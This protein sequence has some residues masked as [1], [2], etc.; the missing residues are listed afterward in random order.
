MEPQRDDRGREGHR[1]G[2]HIADR[3]PSLGV[4]LCYA[5]LAVALC[6][7]AVVHPASHLVGSCCDS[8]V[9]VSYL[10][11]TGVALLHGHQPFITAYLNAPVGVNALWQPSSS[12]ALGVAAIPFELLIGPIATYNLFAIM[13]VAL[14]G[15]SAYLV[16]RRWVGGQT[17]PIV[18]GLVFGFSSYMMVQT[19]AGHLDLTFLALVPPVL[20]IIVSL[21]L[22]HARSPWRSGVALGVLLVVQLLINQEILSDLVIAGLVVTATLAIVC[23]QQVVVAL[24]RLA[25]GVAVAAV[26]FLA[27]GAWPLWTA[28]FGSLRPTNPI[29]APS[30]PTDLLSFVSPTPLISLAPQWLR[31]IDAGWFPDGVDQ[32]SAYIGIVLLGV[33]VAAAIALRR[34]PVVRVASLGAVIMAILSLGPNLRV[35]NHLTGIPLPWAVFDHLPLLRFAVTD[36][37]VV[38]TWLGVAVVLAAFVRAATEAR[39]RGRLLWL[40]A[41][42]TGLV[43]L[44]PFPLTTTSLPTPSIFTDPS[45]TKALPSGGLVYV[46]PFPRAENV[47]PLQWQAETRMRFSMPGGYVLVPTRSGALASTTGAVDDLSQSLLDLQAGRSPPPRIEWP[48]L[49]AELASDRAAAVL[50]GPM[51]HE[52]A[53]REFLTMMLASPPR[54]IG[55]VYV[56]RLG[57]H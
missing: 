15:W 55:G 16:L 27:L 7:K 4:L 29:I 19:I 45:L 39:L 43:L 8:L 2:R 12:I 30:I 14:S 56:W 26:S 41:L 53:V 34:Q 9:A 1:H 42:V 23:R 37:F 48:T 32:S 13:A 28:L 51:D 10:Q 11:S 25:V 50:V 22:G 18:G 24:P 20:A 46:A 38:F 3:L 31:T 52:R 35:A 40:V 5:C 33:T 21:A 54:P 57:R 47:A 6:H 49:R 44:T 36:R 17:G